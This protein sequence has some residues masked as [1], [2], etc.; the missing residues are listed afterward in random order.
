VVLTKTGDHWEATGVTSAKPGKGQ[1]F[2]KGVVDY[3]DYDYSSTDWSNSQN[4]ARKMHITYGIENYFVPEGTG[5]HV[6]SQIGTKQAL[7]QV[8]VDG[9][10]NSV[11]RSLVFG[12]DIGQDNTTN[13]INE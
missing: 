6:V 3:V 10:G 2:I 4:A 13:V 11:L 7:A 12:A 9:D 1:L 5:S 8:V